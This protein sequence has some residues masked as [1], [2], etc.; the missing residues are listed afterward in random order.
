MSFET[1]TFVP[2]VRTGE[3][4]RNRIWMR[5]ITW[6]IDSELFNV[7]I[8]PAVRWR[9]HSRVEC[10]GFQKV[11]CV[12]FFLHIKTM[13]T[14]NRHRTVIAFNIYITYWYDLKCLLL[15]CHWT[16]SGRYF[17]TCS[18]NI[19]CIYFSKTTGFTLKNGRF[20]HY[21]HLTGRLLW[22]HQHCL[23]LR[24]KQHCRPR[25]W[26]SLSHHECGDVHNHFCRPSFDPRGHLRSLFYGRY[27][28]NEIYYRMCVCK[29]SGSVC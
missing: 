28:I 15:S 16:L 11:K 5:V 29:W 12:T 26:K 1:C 17:K 27:I 21:Q 3:E 24:W 22:L 18:L 23:R 8:I 14:A 20:Q 9:E 6:H 25:S 2:S 10:F 19:T 13:R 4:L 7:K